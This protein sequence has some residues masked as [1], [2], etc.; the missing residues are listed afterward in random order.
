[1]PG[2][3][4]ERDLAVMFASSDFG[5]AASSIVWK[6]TVPL[7]GIFDD[8][9]TEIQNGEG[10]VMILAQP[11][12]TVASASVVGIAE[13]D[14]MTVRGVGYEVSHWMDDATGV[15]EIYLRDPD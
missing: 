15:T 1:M 2:A 9:D 10:E 14:A 3:F 8:A 4:L 6:G 12:V 7:S 5:E 11:M 13:G